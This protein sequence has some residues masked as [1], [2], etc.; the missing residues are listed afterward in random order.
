MATVN[1]SIIPELNSLNSCAYNDDLTRM[2]VCNAEGRVQI[3]D[4]LDHQQLW[5]VTTDLP[6]KTKP[7]VTQVNFCEASRR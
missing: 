1:Y 3:C 5:R 7:D 2:I 4:R 6:N